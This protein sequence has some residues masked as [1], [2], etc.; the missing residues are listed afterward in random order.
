MASPIFTGRKRNP[1]NLVNT[2]WDTGQGQGFLLFPYLSDLKFCLYKNHFRAQARTWEFSQNARTSSGEGP[3]G[4]RTDGS[5]DTLG[6]G[7][8]KAWILPPVTQRTPSGCGD[9]PLC[10]TG[11]RRRRPASHRWV[12]PLGVRAPGLGKFSVQSLPPR[13]GRSEQ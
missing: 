12:H 7:C 9:P 6:C 1:I 8:S 3:A 10:P 11:G 13:T 2:S 5:K 4:R